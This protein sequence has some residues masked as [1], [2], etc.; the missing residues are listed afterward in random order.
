MT[1]LSHGNFYMFYDEIRFSKCL[2]MIIL[3][4]FVPDVTAFRS[5]PLDV[6]PWCLLRQI[7]TGLQEADPSSVGIRHYLLSK[8]WLSCFYTQF[9]SSWKV[10]K[11]N[12]HK[13]LKKWSIITCLYN[14]NSNLIYKDR[15]WSM[16]WLIDWLIFNIPSGSRSLVTPYSLSITWKARSILSLTCLLSTCLQS[17]RSG[18]DRVKDNKIV[19][20]I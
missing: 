5:K 15:N 4:N 8:A 14:F 16:H 20:S 13:Y 2:L 9:Y 19:R 18:L 1:M 3:V 10:Y 12:T 11:K 6:R 7:A 17:T